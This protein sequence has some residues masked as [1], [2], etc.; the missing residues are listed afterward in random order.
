[1]EVLL[2]N[3]GYVRSFARLTLED[4]ALVVARRGNSLT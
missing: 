3:R 4:A 2:S 1:V